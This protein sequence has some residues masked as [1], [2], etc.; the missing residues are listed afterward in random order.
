MTWLLLK[1]SLAD[2]AGRDRLLLMQSRRAFVPESYSGDGGFA[3]A[4]PGQKEKKKSIARPTRR[5]SASI[6]MVV[7]GPEQDCF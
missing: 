6:R 5:R 1:S 7:P 4:A 2:K 3:A